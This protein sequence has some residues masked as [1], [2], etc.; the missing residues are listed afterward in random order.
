M[1]TRSTATQ[2]SRKLKL[3]K[4]A[5]PA[6]TKCGG[7]K[8]MVETVIIVKSAA[9]V[10]DKVEAKDVVKVPKV[11]VKNKGEAADMVVDLASVDI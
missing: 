8:D 5:A 1:E 4:A 7:E 2:G 10:K 6:K 11:K 9:E 3:Q